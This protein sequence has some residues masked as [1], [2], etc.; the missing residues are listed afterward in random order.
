[1]I[2][3]RQERTWAS[4]AVLLMVLFAVAAAALAMTTSRS[5][6]DEEQ[7]WDIATSISIGEG[8]ELAGIPTAY[9]AP[10]WPLALTPFAFATG[11]MR[12]THI[13]PVLLFLAA[14]VVAARLGVL[15]TG[16]RLGLLSGVVVMGYPANIYTASTLY[17]QTLALLIILS[18][19]YI[20][21]KN[22][23][24]TR[25]G[26]AT[27]IAFGILLA[28]LALSVPVLAVTAAVLGLAAFWAQRGHRLRFAFVAG[29][30]TLLPVAIWTIRNALCLSSFIPLST[31]NG[32]NL[33]LGN[34]P[35]STATTG[36]GANVT[37]YLHSAAAQGLNEVQRDKYFR[38]V[39]IE[40][41]RNNPADAAWLYL[42]K[43]V[44]YF[45]PF[46]ETTTSEN[47]FSF[48]A[49]IAWASFVILGV[50]FLARIWVH[51]RG[52][53]KMGYSEKLMV[54]L[55]LINAP[56][57]AF[58]FTRLRFRLP[59]DGPLLVMAALPVVLALIRYTSEER[60]STHD[61]AV[62]ERE[63]QH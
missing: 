9:R 15:L 53:L 31:T 22:Q 26:T 56:I 33:M 50:L 41:I 28:M 42:Q 5:Y 32:V 47:T 21:A 57:M 8:Y 46:N 20:L 14:G 48:M 60:T 23:D 10:V 1:M 11:S 35:N 43:L 49:L 29:G 61:E 2:G 17:P 34:S 63:S 13:L 25:M 59:L 12:V 51:R 54:W 40:W 3:G 19:W 7:Y 16:S 39:A 45:S 62:G 55:W 30:V 6:A 27:A 52:I 36:A 18:C 4:A 44:T 37:T 58:H 38:D 24:G